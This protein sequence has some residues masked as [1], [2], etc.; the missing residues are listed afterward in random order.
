M[1]KRN[2]KIIAE[3][4]FWGDRYVA[5]SCYAQ[6]Q[7]GDFIGYGG[8][9][10]SNRTLVVYDLQTGGQVPADVLF[11]EGN[12]I[13]EWTSD[14][15]PCEAPKILT[16]PVGVQIADDHRICFVFSS[17]GKEYACFLAEESI[18]WYD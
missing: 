15:E 5:I 9:V 18:A 11:A 17:E 8:G 14:G 6:T 12:L 7:Y 13:G 16:A 3:P 10:I 4:V 1:Q 2:L